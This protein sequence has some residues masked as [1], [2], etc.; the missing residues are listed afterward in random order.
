MEG[1]HVVRVVVVNF[2]YHVDAGF[3][4]ESRPEAH[5]D[6]HSSV[7]AKAVDRILRDEVVDPCLICGCDFRVFGAQIGEGDFLI[8]EPTLLDIRLGRS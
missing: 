3:A 4:Q 6:F 5:V 1:T 7:K 2:A 8:T